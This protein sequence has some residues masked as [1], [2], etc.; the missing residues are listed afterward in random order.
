MFR[1]SDIVLFAIMVSAAA[2]TYKTKH[3]AERVLSEVARL[4]EQIRL[5]E[6]TIDILKADWGLLAQP[7]RLQ[8]LADVYREELELVPVEARQIVDFDDI[9]VRPLTIEDLS[10]ERLGGMADLPVDTKT[11]GGVTQ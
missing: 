6:D 4:H 11:T 1:T 10:N 9:P 3:D 8:R 7:A 5:E 2:Y